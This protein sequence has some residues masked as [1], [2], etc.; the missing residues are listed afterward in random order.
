MCWWFLWNALLLSSYEFFQRT[1]TKFAISSEWKS[2]PPNYLWW[3][4]SPTLFIK[5]IASI[6]VCWVVKWV[7]NNFAVSFYVLFLVPETF[8]ISITVNKRHA[9]K[10][11]Y[12]LKFIEVYYNISHWSSE[13]VLMISNIFKHTR[14]NKATQ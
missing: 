12:L 13:N 10:Y 2:F 3:K 14:H 11:P 5:K 7:S 9:I 1:F 4:N 6:I 8:L